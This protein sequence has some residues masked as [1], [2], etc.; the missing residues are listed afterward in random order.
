[1]EH[2]LIQVFQRLT[3]Q[4]FLRFSLCRPYNIATAL[5]NI[6]SREI[7]SWKIFTWVLKEM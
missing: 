7:Y 3:W 4:Y 2:E 1:M 6:F 5:L